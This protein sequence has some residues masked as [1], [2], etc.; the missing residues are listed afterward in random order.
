MR[1]PV[2]QARNRGTASANT[3]TQAYQYLQLIVF[4]GALDFSPARTLAASGIAAARQSPYSE[5][6]IEQSKSAS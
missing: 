1:W 2:P 3:G 6:H 5:R 4:F